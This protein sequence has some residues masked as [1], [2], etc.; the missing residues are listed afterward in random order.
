M[1]PRRTG[2]PVRRG[3]MAAPLLSIVIPAYNEAERLPASLEHLRRFL[4]AEQYDAEVLVVD[5]GSIDGTADAVAA[6]AAADARV[7]LVAASHRGKGAAVTRGMLTATG[8]TRLMCDADLSM[9]AG[10]I[11]KLLAAIARGAEVAIATRQGVG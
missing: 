11:P 10:E 7:R 8:S 3:E 6:A 2:S 9:P 4:D 1:R 5:D